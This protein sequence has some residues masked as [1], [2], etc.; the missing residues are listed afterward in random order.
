MKSSII[1]NIEIILNEES[2]FED[3]KDSIDKFY[4]DFAKITSL[5][6]KLEKPERGTVS[7]YGEILSPQT[8]AGSIFDYV[9]TTKFLRGIKKAI[10]HQLANK[11]NNKCKLLAVCPGPFAKLI[12]PLLPLFDES[13][14][15]I[16]VV[17][18]HERSISALNSIIS[19]F[20]FTNSFNQILV[21]DPITFNIDNENKFDIIIIDSIQKAL[22]VEPQVAF[23]NYFSRFLA[24]DGNLIP[25]KIKISA[26]LADLQNELAF[27]KSKFTEFW[28]KIKRNNS[29]NKRIILDDI[30]V[31]DKNIGKNYKM[32]NLTNNQIQLANIKAPNKIG[33]MQHLI[34]LTEILVFDDI[35]ISEEDD[36]GLAKLYFDQ[37]VKSIEEE[38]EIHFA[39]Q[40]GSNPKFLIEPKTIN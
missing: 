36:T 5:T 37:N 26:A 33:R 19:H 12:I 27:S 6:G 2:H 20:G 34:L 14:V 21:Q 15:E 7:F 3:I 28:Q 31:L 25:E 13:Q 22:F 23:T 18:I 4:N 32:H 11:I 24:E 35:I 9:H 40:L 8:S 17:D 39:Y 16:N 10:D 30:F 38:M 29:K 1:D